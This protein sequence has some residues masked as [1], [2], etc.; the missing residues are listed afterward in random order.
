MGWRVYC[1][2]TFGPGGP[3]DW[4]T[5]SQRFHFLIYG[6]LSYFFAWAIKA[7]QNPVKGKRIRLIYILSCYILPAIY[8]AGFIDFDHRCGWNLHFFIWTVL[9]QF[10]VLSLW[11]LRLWLLLILQAAIRKLGDRWGIWGNAVMSAA[12][13]LILYKI[14]KFSLP[15]LLAQFVFL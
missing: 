1:L 9:P 2:Y 12:C 10:I 14:L 4:I 11:V 8:F 13:L 6:V 5:D 7:V 15:T 3:I